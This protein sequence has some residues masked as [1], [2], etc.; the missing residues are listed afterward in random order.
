VT[1]HEEIE[2][3]FASA[4]WDIDDGFSGHLVIGYSSDAL[5]ILAH[6]EHTSETADDP[7][8]EL[9]DHV[10]NVACWVREI[11]TPRQAAQL[12]HEHGEPPEE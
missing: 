12:L 11:P 2:Q 8:F 10:Q 3:R 5:S 6:R 4:G 7:G 9:I 1:T